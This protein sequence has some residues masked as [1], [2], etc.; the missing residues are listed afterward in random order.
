[1]EVNVIEGWIQLELIPIY[2]SLN[3]LTHCLLTVSGKTRLDCLQVR[4][5]SP[6]EESLALYI[7]HL[8]VVFYE[9]LL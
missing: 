6:E 2:C 1:M 7:V 9:N 5:K 8:L 4:E 3:L